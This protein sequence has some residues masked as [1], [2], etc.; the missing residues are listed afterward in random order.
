MVNLYHSVPL[1]SVMCHSLDGFSHLQLDG[2]LNVKGIAL[3]R[4][5]KVQGSAFGLKQS[6][7]WHPSK[8]PMPP[9][10]MQIISDHLSVSNKSYSF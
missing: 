8:S 7:D 9:P 4:T 5:Q 3:P 1:S 6:I 2:L 10:P